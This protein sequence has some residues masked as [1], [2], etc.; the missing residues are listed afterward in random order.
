MAQ[1]A[2]ISRKRE[3]FFINP[4]SLY[5][6]SDMNVHAFTF[7]PFAENTYVLYD[8]TRECIIIDP[9]AVPIPSSRNW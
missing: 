3:A 4:I 5:L 2:Q 6:C 9:G 8:D 7:N 1:A